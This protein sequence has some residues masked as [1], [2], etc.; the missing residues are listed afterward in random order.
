MREEKTKGE[1]R[2]IGYK[3]GGRWR[4]SLREKQGWDESD[5]AIPSLGPPGGPPASHVLVSQTNCI[6]FI[7][8]LC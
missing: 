4:K 2:R 3:R 5:E 6:D 1:K 7:T 8:L